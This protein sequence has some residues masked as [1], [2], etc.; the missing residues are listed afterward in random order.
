MTASIRAGL[1]Y[2]LLVFACGFVLGTLRVTLIIP[3]IGE[4]AAVAL[5]VP[6]LLTLAWL[7]CR[8]LIRRFDVPAV[9]GARL[10][11]G[12]VAFALLMLAELVLSVLLAG[13]TP[14][15]HWALY[16]DLA[17]QIGLVA[18]IGFAAMP[19]LQL[20]RVKSR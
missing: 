1:S 11:M 6:I 2:F 20:H 14:A 4:L 3:R 5:E 18:Q 7:I 15:Q 8:C 13:R 10:V 16:R 9:T 19:L 12:A 17:H